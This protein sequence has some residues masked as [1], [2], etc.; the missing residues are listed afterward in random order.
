MEKYLTLDGIE[1]SPNGQPSFYEYRNADPNSPE[2]GQID[3]PTFLWAGGWF[4]NA[5]Y[6][7][8]GIRED[9]WNMQLTGQLPQNFTNLEY[10]LHLYEKKCRIKWTGN[11]LYV[12]RIVQD[13]KPVHSML[14]TVP[15][16]TIIIERGKPIG[17]YLQISTCP[18][19]S[20]R[21][22]ESESKL[23]VHFKYI[24]PSPVTL[25]MVSPLPCRHLLTSEQDPLNFQT[26]R[27][28]ED[29]YTIIYSGKLNKDC[30][31]VDFQLNAKPE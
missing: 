11:G 5:L 27:V 23:R 2:Y 25:K 21:Y 28:D 8:A 17:P 1:N 26:R 16:R 15:A 18:V 12:R 10:D 14:L 6:Q 30:R 13:G 22:S 29:V 7:V 3:K 4:I 19:H 31:Y 9:P 24:Q 20:V